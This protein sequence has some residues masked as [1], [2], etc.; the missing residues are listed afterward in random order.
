MAHIIRW[1]DPE[2]VWGNFFWGQLVPDTPGWKE[3][4]TMG[5]DIIPHARDAYRTYLTQVAGAA[6]IQGPALGV[7]PAITSGFVATLN[8]QLAR[9]GATDTASTAFNTA[10]ATEKTGRKLTDTVIHETFASW[11]TLPGWG[12]SAIAALQASAPKPP[13]DALNYK[14]G[15]KVSINGGEIR[16]VWTKHGV[17]GVHIYARLAGQTAWVK[18][19]LDTSSPYIDGRPLA[20]AGVAETREYM[21]RGCDINENEIGL[22]SDIVSV[23]FAG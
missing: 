2:A 3:K 7:D 20:V 5:G 9:M 12:N 17:Y 10:D 21:L 19:A 13:F 1:G 8:A 4:K 22:D 14:P 18:I 11:R 15:V 23:L 16:L 6:V